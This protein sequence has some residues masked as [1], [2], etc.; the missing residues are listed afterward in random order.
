MFLRFELKKQTQK[1]FYADGEGN[2]FDAPQ[3]FK[4]QVLLGSMDTRSLL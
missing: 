1:Q 2:Y 3:D 4:V